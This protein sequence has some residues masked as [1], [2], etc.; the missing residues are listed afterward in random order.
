MLF[1]WVA[2]ASMALA[3][4]AEPS[5]AVLPAQFEGTLDAPWR[6]SFEQGL[7][8]QVQAQGARLVSADEVQGDAAGCDQPSCWRAT[9]SAVGA[10]HL[11][12]IVV[13]VQERDFDIAA[14]LIDAT[15]GMVIARGR[16]RCELCG[17]GEAQA[18]TV[19]RVRALLQQ[20]ERRTM[21]G[22][23]IVH[24]TP[25][26]ADLRL[27]GAP[28]GVTPAELSVAPGD[29]VLDV[30][31][32]GYRPTSRTVAMAAGLEQSFDVRLDPVPDQP[33]R[34][35]RPWGWAS[36]G[37]GAGLLAPGIALLVIDQRPY[38]RRCEADATGRC[39]FRY[40]TLAGGIAL[41]SVA[42]ALAITGVVL[43]ATR[44][45]ATR[46]AA[47]EAWRGAGPRWSHRGARLAG[48]PAPRRRTAA[49]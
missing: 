7:G 8:E 35:R 22:T 47:P 34:P 1:A 33:S 46:R 2:A 25:T 11:I 28:V 38:T 10:A 14:E 3:L 9:A 49:P 42:S 26:G 17:V 36:L 21:P 31:R 44:R 19:T 16:D 6:N 20:L 48:T 18:A 39:R 45:R 4:E 15:A 12:R 43:L 24:S 40:D 32:D 30:A 13:Q 29:H 41:T 5:V 37:V 27:D 23:L